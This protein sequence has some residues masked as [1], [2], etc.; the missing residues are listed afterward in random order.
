M[1]SL[2]RR[3]RRAKEAIKILLFASVRDGQGVSATR[4]RSPYLTY[5]S[6]TGMRSLITSD[7]LGA[8]LS[9]GNPSSAGSR[10]LRRRTKIHQARQ[11][12]QPF[13]VPYLSRTSN[14]GHTH[15]L[16]TVGWRRKASTNL[17]DSF[18]GGTT[19]ST[20]IEI[21]SIVQMRDASLQQTSLSR[22]RLRGLGG[23]AA[24]LMRALNQSV[25]RSRS[26]TKPIF[27]L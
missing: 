25:I 20:R 17:L 1:Y 15:H 18:A 26:L 7:A 3:R 8:L 21:L 19:T 13:T 27:N 12:E 16:R 23:P 11:R 2:R 9:L 22:M 4:S 10:P 24:L 5:P 14:L 6:R